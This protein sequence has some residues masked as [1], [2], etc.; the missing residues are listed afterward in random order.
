MRETP[1]FPRAPLWMQWM[2]VRAAVEIV[3]DWIRERLGLTACYGLRPR[4]R[5]IIRLAGG[6]SDR[7]I[8][9]ESPA[10]QSCLRLGLPITHLYA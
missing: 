2:L 5:W 7:I 9:S 8:L 10:A 6:L 1:A 4:E 3:P